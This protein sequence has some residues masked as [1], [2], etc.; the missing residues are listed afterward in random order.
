MTQAT[1]L[2]RLVEVIEVLSLRCSPDQMALGSGRLVS[3]LVFVAA[4]AKRPGA[5]STEPHD[6]RNSSLGRFG[7]TFAGTT[8]GARYSR[9]SMESASESFTNDSVDGLMCTFRLSR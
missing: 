8:Y 4:S 5:S 3:A 1:H 2:N 9:V 7:Q 6:G